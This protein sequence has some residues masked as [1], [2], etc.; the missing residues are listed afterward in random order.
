[1]RRD[2]PTT[3]RAN[4]YAVIMAGG[5]GTRFWPQSR[6]RIPKQFL[7]IAGRRTMLQETARRLRGIVP[8][9][10]VAVVASRE[11]ASLIRAQLPALPA[12]N[13][14]VEPAPRGT[15]ACLALAAEWV[16]RRD[17]AGLMAVFPADHVITEEARFHRALLRAF[18]TAEA[19]RCLVT[20]G[21]PPAYAETGYGYIEVGKR[22]TGTAPRVYWAQRFHEKPDAAAARTYLAA[23][24]YLWNSGMFVWRV[25]VIRD[26]FARHA[27]AIARVMG[28][29]RAG[30][31]GR[32]SVPAPSYRRLRAEPV[33]VAIME[34]AERVAVVEGDFGWSDVGSW[35]A[36]SELWGTDAAGNA[37]R[38]TAV[39]VDCRDTVVYG[40]NRLVAVVGG[41]DLIVVDSPD[42]VLVCPK[43]R[44]Q[45]VRRIV[46]ALTHSR[47]R[48]LL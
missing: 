40:T 44:A 5:F 3:K 35:A 28:R 32:I 39:L 46:A 13:L 4:R 2:T 9:D 42:A 10:H 7:A 30:R 43:S 11:F 38:G 27:P 17:P 6:R 21:V 37:S 22:A 1:M 31:A 41:D 23:G 29:A 18:T 8:A 34:R 15:A 16:A 47:H 20:F 25:D 48:R 36:M 12:A 24:R 26:A 45:D 19:E 14:I 33:D